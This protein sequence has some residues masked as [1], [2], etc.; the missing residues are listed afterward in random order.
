[1]GRP[2][3][4]HA[5]QW[6]D[7]SLPEQVRTV[8]GMGWAGKSGKWVKWGGG[9]WNREKMESSGQIRPGR[10]EISDSSVTF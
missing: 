1:M 6:S 8:H 4:F 2:E 3:P 7:E 10:G 5:Y 9:K